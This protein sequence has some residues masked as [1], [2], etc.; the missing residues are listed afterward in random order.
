M[1]VHKLDDHWEETPRVVPM[2]RMPRSLRADESKNPRKFGDVRKSVDRI[3]RTVGSIECSEERSLVMRMLE[4]KAR[5]MLQLA[6]MKQRYPKILEASVEPESP[7]DAD[8]GAEPERP[9]SKADVDAI[10]ADIRHERI[11]LRKALLLT[12]ARH[13]NVPATEG[14]DPAIVEHDWETLYLGGG[15]Y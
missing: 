1:G 2:A 6:G 7:R 11:S 5:R 15:E 8:G 4:K 13:A 3:G 10:R 12:E 9:L 14:L